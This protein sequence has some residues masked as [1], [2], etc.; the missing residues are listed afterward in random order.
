[1]RVIIGVIWGVLILHGVVI[2]D[3]WIDPLIIAQIESGG[4]ADAIGDGG[5][6]IGMHQIHAGVVKDYNSWNKTSYKHEDMKNSEVSHLVANWYLNTEIP[7]LIRHYK[8]IDSIEARLIAYNA[9]I[10]RL[11]KGTLPKNHPSHQ[12][13]Q[14][15]RS[16]S[17]EMSRMRENEASLRNRVR[18]SSEVL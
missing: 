12:Y 13:I 3:V 11:L 5:L 7:R 2:A 15:Y 8:A 4:R 10:K 6:A 1:M 17:Y 9:G 14:K 16:L 18:K